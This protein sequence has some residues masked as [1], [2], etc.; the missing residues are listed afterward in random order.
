MVPSKTVQ[1]QA[2][3]RR[4]PSNT[5]IRSRQKN[6]HGLL[7]H[8]NRRLSLHLGLDQGADGAQAV[9]GQRQ[10][11]AIVHQRAD[12]RH[13]GLRRVLQSVEE[14]FQDMEDEQA[15]R[16]TGNIGTHWQ[17]L[18]QCLTDGHDALS[19]FDAM[20]VELNKSVKILDETRRRIRIFYREEALAEGS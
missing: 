7:Q 4:H 15:L 16:Q 5:V 2:L 10:G 8:L 19:E 9:Q 11:G 3:A 17:N 20:L 12:R 18:L 14:T 1:D 6:R 13:F